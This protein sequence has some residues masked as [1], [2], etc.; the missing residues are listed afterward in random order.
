MRVSQVRGLGRVL[1]E[2]RPHNLVVPELERLDDSHPSSRVVRVE[3][4]F[5][6]SI[7]YPLWCIFVKNWPNFVSRW[8]VDLTG[9]M[10]WVPYS[11]NPSLLATWSPLRHQ[12]LFHPGFGHPVPNERTKRG[13]ASFSSLLFISTR[14]AYF[15]TWTILYSN[16]RT[17][18]STHSI[19]SIR[20]MCYGN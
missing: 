5:I 11:N 13:A 4:V 1:G 18:S 12:D 7:Q 17:R 2:I 8:E 20:Q 19:L 15:T 6:S 16:S 14:T 9:V 3:W 10:K